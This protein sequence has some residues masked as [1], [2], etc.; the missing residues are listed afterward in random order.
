MYQFDC[1]MC[2]ESL[3]TSSIAEIKDRGRTHLH[4]HHYSE[5][6]E[7]F[8]KKYRGKTCTG[9]CESDFP[10]ETQKGCGFE[11]PTCGHDYFPEFAGQYLWWRLEVE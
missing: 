2:E 1:D 5:L 4:N 9:E 10:V 8:R 11:C 3:E 6:G 7:V